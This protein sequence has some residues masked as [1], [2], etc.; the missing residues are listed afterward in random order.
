MRSRSAFVLLLNASDVREV[1]VQ[2]KVRTDVRQLPL[3]SRGS[4]SSGES[5]AEV[6]LVKHG[7]D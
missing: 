7:S 3:T 1:R 6:C 2:R 5:R 4:R